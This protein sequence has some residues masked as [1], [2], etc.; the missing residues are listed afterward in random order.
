M[1]SD[2]AEGHRQQP[3][4]SLAVVFL[5]GLLFLPEASSAHPSNEQHPEA[6]FLRHRRRPGALGDGTGGHSHHP[7][8]LSSPSAGGNHHG[9]PS[10]RITGGRDVV[11][12]SDSGNVVSPRITG[13]TQAS[14][15]S[16]PFFVLWGGCGAT[17]IHNDVALSA[18]HCTRREDA[19][20]GPRH[21]SDNTDTWAHVEN[22]R[23]HP[24]YDP[25][26]YDYDFAV[27]KLG[28]WFRSETVRL[29]GN[30]NSPGE[31]E[32]MEI[33]GFGGQSPTLKAGRVEAVASGTCAALWDKAGHAI[34]ETASLCAGSR[35]GANPCTG[36]SGGPLLSSSGVQLGV[37][38]S[39]SD[40]CDGR[41]PAVYSRVSAAK[42]W[43]ERQVCE[44]S[45]HPPGYCGGE[46]SGGHRGSGGETVRVDIHLDDYP[47]DIVW[48]ITEAA[49]GVELASGGGFAVPNSLESEFV[50][51]PGGAYYEFTIEDASGFA[52]GLGANG[53][54]AVATVDGGGNDRGTLVS[55]GGNFGQSE[56]SVFAIGDAPDPTR[57]PTTPPPTD[58]PTAGPV[59]APTVSPT[60]PSPPTG[61][62]S[63]G[64]TDGLVAATDA[65]TADRTF[66][67]FERTEPTETSTASGKPT[68]EPTDRFPTP[69]P[70]M[71]RRT[72]E[73]PTIGTTIPLVPRFT[74]EPT[75]APT[76]AGEATEEPTAE[77]TMERTQERTDGPSAPTQITEATDEATPGPTGIP[78]MDPTASPVS[79]KTEE[80]TGEPTPG[81]TPGTGEL[82]F[83]DVFTWRSLSEEDGRPTHSSSPSASPRPS[84]SSLPSDPP[85]TSPEPTAPDTRA[86]T[87]EP[88]DPAPVADGSALV[89]NDP[90]PGDLLFG[91]SGIRFDVSAIFRGPSPAP[92]STP[93]RPVVDGSES[94]MV[95]P[96]P[97]GAPAT[98]GQI[99][100]G[101]S[102]AETG[103]PTVEG[104]TGSSATATAATPTENPTEEVW[105]FPAT[106]RPT[107]SF[108]EESPADDSTDDEPSP[109]PTTRSPTDGPTEATPTDLPADDPSPSPSARM[110][111]DEPTQVSFDDG[112][113]EP[114]PS[115][116]ARSQTDDPTEAPADVSTGVPTA[117]PSTRSPTNSPT[118]DPT[119]FPTAAVSTPAPTAVR[120]TRS[121]AASPTGE[122]VVF[123]RRYL[124]FVNVTIFEE[125]EEVGWRIVDSASKD[126]F[127]GYPTG[128]YRDA[129]TSMKFVSMETGSW[130]FQLTRESVAADAVAEIGYVDAITGEMRLLGEVALSSGSTATTATA[131]ID[132]L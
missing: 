18:A 62:P 42:D 6:S 87:E 81:P 50:A 11:F 37:I 39:G 83:D 35:E 19:R 100:T 54:Y 122:P 40:S 38:S 73:D 51:L 125:P 46:S 23:G 67:L 2:C 106:E 116:T 118:D 53:R 29:N 30:G 84:G 109:S 107:E 27:L 128:N 9:G 131:S 123:V 68:P 91:L 75:G 93:G 13:G 92:T 99:T 59:A 80:P 3:L 32:S 102:S 34:D 44:M 124:G 12:G 97:A 24:L 103:S 4:R 15:S 119:P 7:R 66:S 28:G 72:T 21:R 105:V 64:P 10:P 69:R 26:S 55:G 45:D 25:E 60:A 113:G 61:A 85:T 132:L 120:A 47:G 70:T 111:T 41:L 78:T 31:G 5:L 86:V 130:E 48:R 98:S 43:I 71:L 117:S 89:P 129:T 58:D 90:V 20:V 114:S 14:P 108:V 96:T 126:Q 36:D 16:Y 52:D 1:R 57:T 56:S 112:T 110:P 121:P 94:A 82:L 74:S 33:I 65:P 88:P 95:S 79:V 76:T 127:Y 22:V 49:S 115:P 104:P 77:P 101:V 17:L 63:P 8:S